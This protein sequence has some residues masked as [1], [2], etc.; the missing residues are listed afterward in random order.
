VVA[1][2]SFVVVC[3]GDELLVADADVYAGWVATSCEDGCWEGV[4]V[5]VG[6]DV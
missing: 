2:A 3:A 5:V 6:A 4:L 1:A